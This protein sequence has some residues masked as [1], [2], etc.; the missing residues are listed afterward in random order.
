MR[1]HVGRFPSCRLQPAAEAA[2]P[3]I[4]PGLTP[5]LPPA[6][7]PPLPQSLVYKA[8]QEAEY[9]PL[10]AQAL[11]Q[12]RSAKTGPHDAARPYAGVA[13]VLSTI[14]GAEMLRIVPG[15]VS[16]EVRWAAN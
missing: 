8:V 9:Q 12:A 7:P 11:A 1:L 6:R 10:L 3:E 4:G 13:D 15:R 14:I 2:Q 5:P 16:T